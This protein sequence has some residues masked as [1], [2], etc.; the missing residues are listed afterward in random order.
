MV[1]FFTGLLARVWHSLSSI[2]YIFFT[3]LHRMDCYYKLKSFKFFR[4]YVFPYIVKSAWF[5][6]SQVYFSRGQGS[7]LLSE[8][9]GY[10]KIIFHTN[11]LSFM[12]PVHNLNKESWWF[13]KVGVQGHLWWS[14][15]HMYSCDECNWWSTYCTIRLVIHF[16]FL[17]CWC[18]WYYE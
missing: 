5:I 14:R 13:S 10:E 18:I 16:F 3:G 17:S 9:P 4:T 11:N 12:Y 8:L 1:Y 7:K 6:F 2:W 15:K